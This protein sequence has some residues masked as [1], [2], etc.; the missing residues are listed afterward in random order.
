MLYQLS[1]SRVRQGY[2]H[3]WKRY[4]VTMADMERM[5]ITKR[6][7]ME[8]IVPAHAARIFELLRDERLYRFH[9]G[10]PATVE[11]LEQRFRAWVSRTSPGR[12]QMWLNYALRMKADTTY[13]G[14]VQATIAGDV[15]T[16]GYDVFVPY[17]RRGYATEACTKLIACLFH[18]H[19]VRRIAAVVDTENRASLRLLERLGFNKAWTGPSEDMPGRRDHRYELDKS[20]SKAA[21]PR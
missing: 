17:W 21:Y 1:Y 3:P 2:L 5:L 18:E 7:R 4:P 13:V 6:L 12:T 9:G 19:G 14:W 20:V 8:P 10:R 11:Q 16:I 15:A